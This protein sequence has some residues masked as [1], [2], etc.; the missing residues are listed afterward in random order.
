MKKIIL[1]LGIVLFSFGAYAQSPVNFG[2]KA[3]ITSAKLKTD[4]DD[5]TEEAKTGFEAGLFARVNIKKFY[6][7]PE[8]YYAVKGGI[9]KDGSLEQEIQLNTL[10]VPIL[11][12][13]KI[14]GK[15]AFNFRVFAGPVASF[16]V[17]K[18]VDSGSDIIDDIVEKSLAD[19]IWGAQMGA[20][21][22]VLI[23]TLD[24]R[25]EIGFNDLSDVSGSSMK[26]NAFHVSLG[27]K[28][29]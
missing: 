13:Y 21:I 11:V 8:L 7:Q 26:S 18:K 15:G 19:A 22:D 5:I 27:W 23:F 12:G 14:I 2:I 17:N 20:G 29:L 6:L 10:D 9:I 4:I 3:G 25:Y 24:L 28:I 1:L 16:I